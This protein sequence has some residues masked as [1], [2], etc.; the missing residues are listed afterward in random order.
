MYYT[1]STFWAYLL[2]IIALSLVLWP[3]VMPRASSYWPSFWCKSLLVLSLASWLLHFVVPNEPSRIILARIAL[4]F[5]LLSVGAFGYIWFR[6]RRDGLLHIQNFL[7]NI[8]ATL[9][10][11]AIV[12]NAKLKVIDAIGAQR[13]PVTT[14][15][16]DGEPSSICTQLL[17][18]PKSWQTILPKDIV[19]KVNSRVDTTGAVHWGASVI[20]YRF[21]QLGVAGY[22]LLFRD[23]TQEHL[24]I[25]Q[26]EQKN[27]ELNKQRA[28]AQV[29]Y[30]NSAYR[31]E[32][33][34]QN[35]MLHKLETIVQ[36]QVYTLR[37]AFEA[38]ASVDVLIEL[39]ELSLKNIRTIVKKLEQQVQA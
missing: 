18:H 28:L 34:L 11:S 17:N 1:Y 33:N 36:K 27:L 32:V 37:N 38:G 20:Q 19:Q 10:E 9:R 16:I 30:S 4:Q 25:E 6:A 3:D 5:G 21:M 12:F 13:I 23:I 39:T 35:E 31:Q 26:L 7:P 2:G 14:D 8:I 22:M 29:L 15:C 24:L